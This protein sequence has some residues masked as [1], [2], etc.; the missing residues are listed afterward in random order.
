MKFC[1][2]SSTCPSE[3]YASNTITEAKYTRKQHYMLLEFYSDQ[4]WR[5][6]ATCATALELLNPSRLELET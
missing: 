3:L 1:N 4:H 5:S 2:I 6:T